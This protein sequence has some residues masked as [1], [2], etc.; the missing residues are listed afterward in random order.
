MTIE[1]HKITARIGAVVRGI[2]IGAELDA[3]TVLALRNA[4]NEHKALV[5]DDVHLDDAGQQRFARSFGDLT[6]AHPTVPGQPGEANVLPVDSEENRAN[7]WHT[8]V[9]FVL[10]PPQL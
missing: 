9:T 4:L 1:V 5:F 3:A 8:D 2:D 6:T 7:R 10:N